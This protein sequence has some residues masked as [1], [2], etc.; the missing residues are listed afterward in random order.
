MKSV[1]GAVQTGSL[2][3]AVCA[4]SLEGLNCLRHNY[5]LLSLACHKTHLVYRG[6]LCV[7]F[8]TGCLIPDSCPF[9]QCGKEIQ[10]SPGTKLSG[11]QRHSGCTVS[12]R[13]QTHL[14]SP[15][16]GNLMKIKN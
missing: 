6:K 11:F 4:S 2:N 1:Y 3:K 7:S 15:Q 12:A 14:F 16:P 8:G 5:F 9:Y 13:D 10:V